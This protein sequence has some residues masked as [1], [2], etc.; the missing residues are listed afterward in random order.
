MTWR[1]PKVWGSFCGLANPRIDTECVITYDD[2]FK[3]PFSRFE[4]YLEGQ[5][6]KPWLGT[7]NNDA[8]AAGGARFG[9]SG[10]AETRPALQRE[11][12]AE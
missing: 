5:K 1:R 9:T 10:S 12:D 4:T 3:R 11:H 7:G 6:A 2:L 8:S